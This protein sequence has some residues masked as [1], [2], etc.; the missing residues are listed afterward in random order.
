M[1]GILTYYKRDGLSSEDI[2][3]A[4]K[5]LGLI[6]HRGPDG[7]GLVLINTKS[8]NFKIIK[9]P[10]TP[11]EIQSEILIND[12]NDKEF[13]LLLG[14]RRLSIIE[15]SNAG[16]QPMMD[17]LGNWITFNGEI[18]NYLEIRKELKALGIGFKTNSDT[19]VILKAYQY[20]GADC[21]SK[22]NGMWSFLIFNNQSKSLFISNDR[23]GVK[24][25]YLYEDNGSL[26]FV[27]EPK[28]MFA[29]QGKLKSHN[30]NTIQDF[31]KF[32]YLDHNFETFY[33]EL[34]R[35]PNSCYCE[36]N[37]SSYNGKL[38]SIIKNYYNLP[39]TVSDLNYKNAKEKFR[40]LLQDAVKL[41]MRSD[42]P[43]AFALSGGL[44]SSAILY[45]ATDVNK[46]RAS[47]ESIESFSAVFYDL[48]GD[49][50]KFMKIIEHDMNLKTNY[51]EPLKMF[52]M[53][54]F[55]NHIYHQDSPVQSTSYFAEYCIAK[56]VSKKGFKVLL[57]GQGADEIF[58]GYHHHFY[59]FIKSLF[60]NVNIYKLHNEMKA[61]AK[62]KNMTMKSLR[63]RLYNDLKQYVKTLYK[64][65]SHQNNVLSEWKKVK[66]LNDILKLDFTK[67]TLPVYLKS[68]DR[69]GMAFSIESRHPFLDYRLVDFAFSLPDDF[70]IRNGWQKNIIRDAMVEMP[71]EIRFRKDKKGFTTPQD[72]WLSKYKNELEVYKSYLNN[73]SNNSSDEFREISLG[74]W[75]K[76][77][78]I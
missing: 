55:E 35:F 25:L 43:Y 62:L 11:K 6:K 57:V 47:L 63:S 19:E 3:N 31:L 38:N 17:E 49:E 52:N 8:G 50:S 33:N 28:Q 71:E 73:Y 34:N 61:Y 60:L 65:N 9:T 18:Y 20:W 72:Y 78:K 59:T 12:I 53:D 76:Q 46:E 10:E 24:P 32:G 44:D 5:S 2:V 27:S 29:F 4:Q 66:N 56:H 21:L 67:T 77:N 48:D 36:F 69:D 1:C 41:R 23:F 70:K 64:G 68:D 74:V 13:D 51:I 26:I 40:H 58:A 7:E 15:L 37:F 16:H 22:F 39:S 14:H 54:E 75:L 42:V 45:T 30:Q